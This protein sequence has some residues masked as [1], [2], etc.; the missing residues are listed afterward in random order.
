MGGYALSLAEFAVVRPGA[1]AK[2]ARKC[3]EYTIEAQ[4]TIFKSGA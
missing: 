1:T 4:E 3:L 2:D